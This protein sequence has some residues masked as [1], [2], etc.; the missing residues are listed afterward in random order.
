MYDNG[1]AIF[2]SILHCRMTNIC[3]TEAS[4]IW[5]IYTNRAR[6]TKKQYYFQS[7]NCQNYLLHFRLL[8]FRLGPPNRKCNN[9][10]CNTFHKTCI[11]EGLGKNRLD[12]VWRREV[13]SVSWEL[14]TEFSCNF[15]KQHR[16]WLFIF[17]RLLEL[18]YFIKNIERDVRIL[19]SIIQTLADYCYI[20]GYYF[21]GCDHPTENVITENVIHS[22]KLV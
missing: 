11:K 9:R 17:S 5:V 12:K 4:Y 21:S 2:K 7:K 14:L 16:Y 13:E 20:F 10:K 3:W 6:E 8:H 1:N 18:N 15:I 19:L 22:T